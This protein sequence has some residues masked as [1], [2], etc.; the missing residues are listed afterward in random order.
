[1]KIVGIIPARYGSIR[2]PGKPLAD[3]NGKSMIE[4]VYEQAIKCK[5]LNEV[6]IATDDRRIHSAAKKFKG[7]VMMTSRR[8]T[9][10]TER[11]NE[12]IKKLER[13]YDAVINIQGDEPFIQPEQISEVANCLR[14]GRS[15]KKIQIATLVMKIT[16]LHELENPDSVKVVI[17]KKKEAL[18]FSRAVV[19]YYRGEGIST[20]M[21]SHSYYK[22]I[23]LY[24]YGTNV[25]N[26]I[27][28]LKR[29]PL[30]V[31]ESLEQLRWLENG[32]KITVQTTDFPSFS[33][34]TPEDLKHAIKKYFK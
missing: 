34:D 19:P 29:S 15:D 2:F 32:Y 23:G 6:V 20:W 3:I 33:I 31:A 17:N 14:S 9:S 11:C 4:R 25:L 7:N 1:M 16:N 13:K 22:H 8:H 26:E 10:G 30:E 5:H 27:A 28:R 21:N 12:V 24:G 18:Y